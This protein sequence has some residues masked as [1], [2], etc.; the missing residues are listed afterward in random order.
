M[1]KIKDFLTREKL[2]VSFGEARRIA[3]TGQIKVNGLAVNSI[4]AEIKTGDHIEVFKQVSKVIDLS[5]WGENH[6][7][8][9]LF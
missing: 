5:T 6:E 8:N 4:E 9:H 2:I 3:M 1:P 7:S